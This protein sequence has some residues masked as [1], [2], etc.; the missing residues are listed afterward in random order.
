MMVLLLVAGFLAGTMN[1]LAGGGSFLTFPALLL[2]GL[3]ARAANIT[4]TI[5]LFPGQIATGW[6]GWQLVRGEDQAVL[7]VPLM[8]GYAPRARAPDA[9]AA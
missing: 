8:P 2:S 9:P 4:S 5:A 6:A 1:A 3:D 7:A